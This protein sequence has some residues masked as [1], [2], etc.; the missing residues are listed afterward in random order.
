MIQQPTIN[1]L[2]VIERTYQTNEQTKMTSIEQ[3][4]RYAAVLRDEVQSSYRA[5]VAKNTRLY[6]IAH[7]PKASKEYIWPSQMYDAQAIVNLML[8]DNTVELPE[9]QYPPSLIGAHKQPQVGWEGIMIYIAYLMC[10]HPDDDV[11]VNFE[12]VAFITAMSNSDWQKDARDRAPQCFANQIFHHGNL[13]KALGLTKKIVREGGIVFIDE[14]QIGSQ[15]GQKLHQLLQE[16]G[17]LDINNLREK[18]IKIVV[19]SATMIKFL[20]QAA[21][22]GNDFALY[23][24]TI[25]ADYLG[26]KQLKE[27]HILRE[28]KNMN[29]KANTMQWFTDI[30]TFY[31]NEYRVH[32][33]R[34]SP[35]MIAFI[36][37]CAIEMGYGILSHTSKQKL[38]DEDKQRLFVDPLTRHW[39][40]T[41]KDLWRA[42]NRIP[43]SYKPRIGSVHE[44]YV[45]KVDD[46]VE[47]QGLLG[48]MLGFN[49]Y[50]EG[51]KF[52]P[53]Y[54]S[55]TAVDEYISFA[56]DPFKRNSVY[57]CARYSRNRDGRVKTTEKSAMSPSNVANLVATAGI[58]NPLFVTDPKTFSVFKRSEDAKQYATELGYQ[59]REDVI[60]QTLPTS[61]GFIVCGLNAARQVHTIY[62]VINGVRS[63]YGGG[64]G[65]RTC[66]P[67][68]LSTAD[69]S[70]VFFV[71]IIREPDYTNEQRMVVL[72][73]RFA[74]KRVEFD[75]YQPNQY[76]YI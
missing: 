22:W 60:T 17:L 43:K 66:L 49:E 71:V 57:K 73:Q 7:D 34:G 4:Q 40:V 16:S 59:W 72:N 52:G 48:R 63:A 25:P 29:T 18:K 11:L 50:P 2:K 53:Y 9:G 54:T 19:G 28:W 30:D 10:T 38:T 46:D 31:H 20:H 67:G 44:Q 47:A 75:K 14:I 1:Q 42:A 62:E 23:N 70:S 51:H 74:G 69:I 6:E 41:V 13:Q 24:I 21:R 45:R 56:E 26:F 5:A 36:N 33:V 65:V 37:E 15:D 55:L 32:L 61:N 58:R 8:G 27:K 3:R 12:N 39:I 76:K 64:E 68:Y 35:K